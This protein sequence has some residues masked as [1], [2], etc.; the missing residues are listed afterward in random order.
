MK[1][2]LTEAST[3][4]PEGEASEP[5]TTL[6]VYIPACGA[7]HNMLWWTRGCPIIRT[8]APEAANDKT[9]SEETDDAA[10]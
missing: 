6:A 4:R 2:P 3:A 10:R 7:L 8:R 5:S 9:H 1:P